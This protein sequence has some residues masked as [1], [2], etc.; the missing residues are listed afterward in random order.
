MPVECPDSFDD[1]RSQE[2]EVTPVHELKIEVQQLRRD[3]KPIRIELVRASQER[4]RLIV[5]HQLVEQ[6]P[7]IREHLR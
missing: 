6:K 5:S 7:Q 1:L 3:L 4:P 2:V